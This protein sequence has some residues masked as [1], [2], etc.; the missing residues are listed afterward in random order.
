MNNDFQVELYGEI[1]L[2]RNVLF[3]AWKK[4]QGISASSK[5]CS[6]SAVSS[7]T[8]SPHHYSSS[9]ALVSQ[10]S[11]ISWISSSIIWDWIYRCWIV[12]SHWPLDFFA[13]MSREATLFIF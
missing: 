1:W 12:D 10:D 5:S 9:L 4:S 2:C 6:L 7:H 3:H 13:C 11:W 8:I